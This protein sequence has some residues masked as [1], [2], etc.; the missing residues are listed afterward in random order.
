MDPDMTREANNIVRLSLGDWVKIAGVAL[1]L[2]GSLIGV[3]IHH[4]RMLTQLIVQQQYTNQR[5]DK[6]E[7]KL[8]E[9][10]RR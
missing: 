5:L 8:D 4:D 10:H 7:V 6:I 3:Y 9:N 1:T 2:F